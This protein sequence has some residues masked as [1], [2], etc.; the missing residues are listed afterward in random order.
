[1]TKQFFTITL[2][3]VDSDGLVAI[4]TQPGVE[5]DS[6]KVIT[7]E[8]PKQN[9]RQRTSG[10]DT[11]LRLHPSK[12]THSSGQKLKVQ[13]ALVKWSTLSNAPATRATIQ[14][15]AQRQCPDIPRSGMSPILSDLIKEGVLEIA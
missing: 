10:P 13:Q 12:R 3:P 7:S 5:V 1:M 15:Y 9:G 8:P 4:L 14:A 11:K 2:K 6:I